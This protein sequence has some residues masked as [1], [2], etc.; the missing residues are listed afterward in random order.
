MRKVGSVKYEDI[1][2]EGCDCCCCCCCCCDFEL[3][4]SIMGNQWSEDNGWN[5]R[6]TKS[7]F[8]GGHPLL[9]LGNSLSNRNDENKNTLEPIIQG[10]RLNNTCNSSNMSVTYSYHQILFGMVD[11]WTNIVWVKLIVEDFQ[12]MCHV[13]KVNPDTRWV[14]AFSFSQSKT[15]PAVWILIEIYEALIERIPYRAGSQ[16]GMDAHGQINEWWFYWTF[17]WW[18][19]N[20]S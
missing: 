19:F 7:F 16:R 2:C 11:S 8:Y 9:L 4:A 15:T 6:H 12:T 3:N 13:Y 10:Y 1:T 17:H 18:V 5:N 14:L 20:S